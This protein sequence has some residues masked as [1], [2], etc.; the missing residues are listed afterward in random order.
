MADSEAMKALRRAQGGGE[1]LSGQ[2]GDASPTRQPAIEHNRATGPKKL[3]YIRLRLR[4]RAENN[5]LFCR[6]SLPGPFGQ[7]K[8][9]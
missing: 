3:R 7:I 2:S 1:M 8:R 4:Q 9:S 5:F 6:D